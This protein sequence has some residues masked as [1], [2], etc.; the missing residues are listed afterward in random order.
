VVRPSIRVHESRT[1]SGIP[2]HE[3]SMIAHTLDTHAKVNDAVRPVGVDPAEMDVLVINLNRSPERLAFMAAQLGR[4]GLAFVR[5]S[6]VDGAAIPAKEFDRLSRTYMRP[7]SRPELGCL[8]SHASAWRHCVE[9]GRPA[10][11]LEDDAF[12]SDKLPA[13]LSELGRNGTYG[14]VNLETQGTRKWVSRRPLAWQADCGVALYNLYIDRGGSAGY[15]AWPETARKLLERSRNYAAPADAFLD[16]CGMARFQAEPGLVASLYRAEDPNLRV[17][18]AFKST[19]PK[20]SKAFRRSLI[21]HPWFKLRRLAGYISKTSRKI[22]TI[23]IGTHRRI[24]ICSTIRARAD[25]WR[26]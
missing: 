23:G 4:L 11:I 10:L 3:K 20:P 19:N 16:L 2:A 9:T 8:L 24:E 21:L 6:A 15:V 1:S 12:L 17:A 13:F 22:R 26:N 5:S 14:I 18:P 7:L 25:D